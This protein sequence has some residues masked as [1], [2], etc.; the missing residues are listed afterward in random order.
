M[1]T[2]CH[3][4]VNSLNQCQGRRGAM[5]NRGVLLCGPCCSFADLTRCLGK[6]REEVG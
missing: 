6:G 5:G 3:G 4:L 2:G 1:L